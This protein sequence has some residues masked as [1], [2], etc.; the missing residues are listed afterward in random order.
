MI[1]REKILGG[2]QGKIGGRRGGGGGGERDK[3]RKEEGTE[4]KN[5]KIKIKK[6]RRMEMRYI[7]NQ[8]RR[9]TKGEKGKTPK[10]SRRIN[11][12]TQMCVCTHMGVRIRVHAHGHTT[13]A[14][15]LVTVS[16]NGYSSCCLSIPLTC[17]GFQKRAWSPDK[18]LW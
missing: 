8:E 17:S 16:A 13:H 6:R 9:K 5:Q 12:Y 15:F 7:A 18:A 10:I 14:L 3:K 1:N 2:M 11:T 4:E